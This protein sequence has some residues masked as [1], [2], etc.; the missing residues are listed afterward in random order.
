MESKYIFRL[1]Y[2]TAFWYLLIGFLLFTAAGT[3]KWPSAWI[4]ICL[5][6]IPGLG[7]GFWLAKHDPA[8]LK[9][10]LSFIIQRE[11]KRWDKFLMVILMVL[12]L[13]WFPLMALDAERY[14]LSHVP[15]ALK[16]ISAI[17]LLLSTYIIYLV[18]K[19]NSYAA[20][21]VKIQKERGQK[22]INTGPYHWVRHP[23]YAGALLFFI[24]TPLLLGSWYGLIFSFIFIMLLAIRAQME[25]QVLINELHS[26]YIEYK[27]HVRYR[28]VPFIW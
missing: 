21:V 4:F 18:F 25:E 11:Q 9:E 12:I 28:F 15:I 19:E 22:I 20:P 27:N 10:R 8:L 2:Q 26:Q 17:M 24:C 3:I 1:L 7:V 5:Q 23:M 14:H 6:I 13:L 16:F